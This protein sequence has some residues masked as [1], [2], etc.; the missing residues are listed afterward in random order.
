MDV[1]ED[2][3]EEGGDGGWCGKARGM[4]EMTLS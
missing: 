2:E 1:D 3:D 4:E